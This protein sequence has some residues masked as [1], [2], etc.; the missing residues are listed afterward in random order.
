MSGLKWE[1]SIRLVQ[2]SFVK[3]I[4]EGVAAEHWRYSAPQSN[5]PRI[6]Q[7]WWGQPIVDSDLVFR[8][9]QY[10]DWREIMLG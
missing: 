2:N 7:E 5:N 4:V 8:C 3:V 9:V 6:R 1:L 10:S